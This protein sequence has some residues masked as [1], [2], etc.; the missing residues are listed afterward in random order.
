MYDDAE[1]EDKTARDMS[2]RSV[3]RAP[4][5]NNAPKFPDQDLGTIGVQT[6]QTRKVAENTPAGTNLGAPVVG[7]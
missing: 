2:Y 1:G 6:A 5:T 3:R 7:H 4:G